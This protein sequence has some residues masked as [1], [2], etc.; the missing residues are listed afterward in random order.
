MTYNSGAVC[1]GVCRPSSRASHSYRY[2]ISLAGQTC[3]NFSS[4]TCWVDHLVFLAAA[5]ILRTQSRSCT[6]AGWPSGVDRFRVDLFNTQKLF[7]I[8]DNMFQCCHFKWYWWWHVHFSL[9]TEI[10][11]QS[12]ATCVWENISGFGV[13]SCAMPSPIPNLL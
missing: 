2:T 6:T 1:D 4:P 13:L 7:I 9:R 12:L 11:V 5:G 10:W 3:Y 8:A